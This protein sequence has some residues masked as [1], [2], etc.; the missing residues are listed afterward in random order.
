MFQ[1][2]V[3]H[4]SYCLN[5][6]RI[7]HTLWEYIRLSEKEGCVDSPCGPQLQFHLVLPRFR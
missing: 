1:K 7:L 5:S 6:Q 3:P 4:L 2:D